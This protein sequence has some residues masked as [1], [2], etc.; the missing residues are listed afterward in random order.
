MAAQKPR[1]WIFGDSF[2]SDWAAGSH[3]QSWVTELSESEDVVAVN[4]A[5]GG[6]STETAI[7]RFYDSSREIR[8]GDWVI[9]GFSTLARL[10][11]REINRS[12]PDQACSVWNRPITHIWTQENLPEIEW[13]IE[14][15]DL[16]LLKLNFLAYRQMLRTLA[17]QQ[18]EVRVLVVYNTLLEK[19]WSVDRA[20]VANYWEYPLALNEI[21]QNEFKDAQ[22]Y[23]QAIGSLGWDPRINHLC[24]PNRQILKEQCREFLVQGRTPSVSYEDFQK[25][26]F[27]TV[28]NTKDVN[29]LIALGLLKGRASTRREG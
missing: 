16:D 9:F 6:S 21:S 18:P 24:E 10:H 8:G 27:P 15:V 5:L 1:A 25:R 17:R 28:R 11:F 29:D 14:N 13:W 2:V 7:L 26:C 12:R 3:A 19:T 20:T 23:D 4:R 22:T